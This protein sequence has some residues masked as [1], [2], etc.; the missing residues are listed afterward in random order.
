MRDIQFRLFT[1]GDKSIVT[2]PDSTIKAIEEI[3]DMMRVLLLVYHGH[4][5]GKWSRDALLK[6][7]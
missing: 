1:K 6:I 3:F 4:D 7:S 5:E 2:K